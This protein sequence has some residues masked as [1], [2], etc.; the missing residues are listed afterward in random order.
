MQVNS[1]F[2]VKVKKKISGRYFE[3]EVLEKKVDSK[4]KIFRRNRVI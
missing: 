1:T 3:C 2:L 4:S